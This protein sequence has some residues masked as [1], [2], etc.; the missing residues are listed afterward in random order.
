MPTSYTFISIHDYQ[1]GNPSPEAFEAFDICSPITRQQPLRADGCFTGFRSF[2]KIYGEPTQLCPMNYC[3]I[4]IQLVFMFTNSQLY[5]YLS[6]LFS[7]ASC[8][9]TDLG[10]I[11][12]IIIIPCPFFFIIQIP[13]LREG[14]IPTRTG[15]RISDS[16]LVLS[17]CALMNLEMSV[18]VILT[19]LTVYHG[20]GNE[21]R[22]SCSPLL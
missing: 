4:L 6:I 19:I 14:R 12:R 5:A 7:I 20:T 17:H 8:T 3:N 13:Q 1:I 2:W 11:N 9:S 16:V 21:L 15:Q 10:R 22:A 18:V